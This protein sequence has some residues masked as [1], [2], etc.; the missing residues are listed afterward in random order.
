MKKEYH[1][2]KATEI[3]RL[4]TKMWG[5]YR[6]ETLYTS[7]KDETDSL[8]NK[9]DGPARVKLSTDILMHFLIKNHVSL[10]LR[11]AKSWWHVM[12]MEIE[13]Y[14]DEDRE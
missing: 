14:T 2:L 7:S 9:E 11:F 5:S 3:R 12:D 6:S 4:S 8:T 1:I 10:K 13:D